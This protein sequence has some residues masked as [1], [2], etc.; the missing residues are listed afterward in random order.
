VEW[1]VIIGL[2]V[3]A[4]KLWLRVDALEE[5][6]HWAE[7][8]APRAEPPAP[9]AA[10][11][12]AA[13]AA[14]AKPDGEPIAGPPRGVRLVTS[15]KPP[16]PQP[17]P[18]AVALQAPEHP[19]QEMAAPA[20][21]KFKFDFEDI[22]GRRL[23]I[24][25]GGI[26]LAI[27]GVFL[28]R[29]S[30]EAGLLTPQVRVILS[31]VFGLLL[32]AAGEA[33]YRFEARVRDTRV[34]QALAGAGLATLY[35]GFYL[36]GSQYALI[37]AGASF[38]GLAAVTALAI[39]LSFRF[40][41]P[42]A[43]LGLLGGFAAP[44]LVASDEANVPVLTLYLA[45]ITAG[46][47]FTGRRQGH[48]W[49]GY[50]A[51]GGGFLWGMA[52]LT[53]GLAET[54][55]LLSFGLYL[56]AM[57]AVLPLLTGAGPGA[58]WPRIGAAV[59]AS[60]QLAALIELAGFRPLTWALY[61]LLGAALAVLSW[62]ERQLREASAFAAGL[63][64]WLLAFWDQPAAKEY[65]AVAAG[66]AA[67]AVAAPLAFLCFER[68]RKLDLWQLSLAAPALVVVNYAQFGA[69][70]TA[71][72]EPIL[73]AVTFA[74]GIAPALA[75]WRGWR[76]DEGT[77]SVIVPVTSAAALAFAALLMLV[78][79]WAAPL[80]AAAVALALAPLA[81]RRPRPALLN[82]AGAGALVALVT[83]LATPDALVE[84]GLLAN[85]RGET[86]RVHAIVRWL[87]TGLPFL[88]L[89]RLEPRLLV[90]T[91]AEALAA[92][93]AY[94][95]AAQVL[96]PD[97]LA[98]I[99][100]LGAIA[101]C[102]T[103]AKRIGGWGAMIAIA[104]LW[105]LAP[106]SE[107]ISHGT[108]ALFG[109]PLLLDGV[110]D[111][112]EVL[113]RLVPFALAASVAAWRNRHDQVVSLAFVVVAG[114]AAF[115]AAH[116]LYKLVFAIGSTEAFT[117]LGMGERTICQA[118]LAGAG[119]AL[120]WRGPIVWK[121]PAAIALLAL[122]LA[123]FV[124]FTLVMHDPLWQAQTVGPW[125]LINWLLPAYGIAAVAL[126]AL[127]RELAEAASIDAAW[128]DWI[129]DAVL[130][131]LIAL[132]TVSELRQ[133]F[134]GSLLVAAPMTQSEDLLRSLLGIG[135]A[136][137][138]LAWGSHRGERSWR[139]GSLV[140]MLL[141]VG[142]VFLVDA[143]GLEGLLRV[144]SFMALGFSLIGIGWVYARQLAV[145]NAPAEAG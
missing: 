77:V 38:V 93:L 107:W 122:S 120:G 23:P 24:W 125:P 127:H 18:R 2:V 119:L 68:G 57:G 35:A 3:V 103:H 22:F 33:A 130:M 131:A 11:V 84:G 94:G 67:I 145:R 59:L 114:I 4:V 47:A 80:A 74:L 54:T 10:A 96:P 63:G 64:V 144:A 69:W 113:L 40:G 136:I 97:W 91:A 140:L 124:W 29:F 34:R 61:L 50:A 137:A 7:P 82:L 25:A 87:A 70:N 95:A 27:A 110:P 100:A 17:A 141:A 90:R 21:A 72:P 51:L 56:T 30:I 102:L 88:A 6:L 37:G 112:P 105:T 43:V 9:A 134:S 81:W 49:L 132:F 5:R 79:A 14:T 118:L 8:T 39:V 20:A 78:A 19:T 26:A 66:F 126:I 52:L 133:M 111:W 128:F 31:F 106:L 116:S 99:T 45:L 142:K 129:A 75:A 13:P 53:S 42:C 138:F 143:A 44:A 12:H 32:L 108:A 60:L 115:V 135:L 86:D 46:L 109:I 28:V 139:I 15:R 71:G 104:L 83:L 16:E 73:A 123:H 41:L 36:A 76:R 117:S 98:W 55:D 121:R 62:R 1:L 92:L 89:T 101:L 65:A 48:A 85:L 58:Q